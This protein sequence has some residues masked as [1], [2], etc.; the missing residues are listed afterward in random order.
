MTPPLCWSWQGVPLK[1]EIFPTTRT[2]CLQTCCA[3]SNWPASVPTPSVPVRPFDYL[4]HCMCSK[5]RHSPSTLQYGT[6][7]C[8]KFIVWC[9]SVN[10]VG[11]SQIPRCHFTISVIK[12]DNFFQ[13]G[14]HDLCGEAHQHCVTLTVSS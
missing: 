9:T 11:L 13:V 7:Q 14:K 12:S 1:A 3:T 10:G 4:Y 8:S 5:S 6:L 2:S